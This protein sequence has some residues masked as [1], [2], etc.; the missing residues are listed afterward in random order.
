LRAVR[1]QTFS[2]DMPALPV[3]RLARRA[4]RTAA[5]RT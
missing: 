2:E 3:A 1:R 4:E 5:R